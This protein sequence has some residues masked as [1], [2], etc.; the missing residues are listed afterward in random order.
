MK[1]ISS[2]FIFL[3]LSAALFAQSEEEITKDSTKYNLIKIHK[4]FR[5]ES[6]PNL[7]IDGDPFNYFIQRQNFFAGGFGISYLRNLKNDGQFEVGIAEIMFGKGIKTTTWTEGDTLI[8]GRIN[9]I[10]YKRLDIIGEINYAHK[11]G[12]AIS[13]K[14]RFMAGASLMPFI[15][16]FELGPTTD[17]FPVSINIIGVTVSAYPAMQFKIFENGWIDLRI[18]FQLVRIAGVTGENEP[19]FLNLFEEQQRQTDFELLPPIYEVRI[20]LGIGF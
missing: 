9:E 11:I 2:I 12:E 18:P 8:Y 14:W 17:G 16:S 1:P 19:E 5:F 6:M 15:Q 3:F 7:I 13:G 20:G 10:E 4:N